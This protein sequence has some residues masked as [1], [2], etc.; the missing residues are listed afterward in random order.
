MEYIS[1][2][3]KFAHIPTPDNQ[4]FHVP[5][6]GKWNTARG[7]IFHCTH[8]EQCEFDIPNSVKIQPLQLSDPECSLDIEKCIKI[9]HSSSLTMAILPAMKSRII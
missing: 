5:S 4:I 7:L 6:S 8:R 3:I 9:H 2:G 1:Y